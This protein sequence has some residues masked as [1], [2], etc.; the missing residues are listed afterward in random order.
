MNGAT[1]EAA[2]RWVDAYLA[3]LPEDQREALE[4]LRAQI[5]RAAPDAVEQVSYS[6]PAFRLGGR[7]LVYYA[8]FK[9]HLSLFPAS[10]SVRERLG[11][12]LRANFRGKGTIQ[13]TPQAPLSPR[14]VEQI[15]AARRAEITSGGR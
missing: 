7:V 4:T 1:G 13:F 3:A 9:D 14:L 6:M 15:V 8:A 12:D 2:A 11:D 5:R 10:G